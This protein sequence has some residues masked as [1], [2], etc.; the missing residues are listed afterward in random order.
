MEELKNK[1][2]NSQI[3]RSIFRHGYPDTEKNR[4]LIIITNFFL[5][6]HPAKMKKHGMKITYTWC[7]GGISFF[8]F[9]VLTVTGILLMFYYRPTVE[10]AYHDMKDLEFVVT[11]GILLRNLH[12]WA[13]HGMV[14]TVI[15]HMV[16]VFLTGSY[17]PPREF[18]WGIGVSL[19]VLTV[20]LSYTG[21]LLP[22]DQLAFWGVTVGTN[23][24]S[25][26]PFLGSEGP[27][28]IVD[29]G[30]D[31]RFLMLGGRTVGQ[32]ALLRFY[33]L[34]VIALPLI[35]VIFMAVHFWR[36]RKDGGIS[37]PL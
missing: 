34:H 26:V 18:N 35:M 6:L 33:V 9:F 17:R 28:S 14:L 16:R 8:L 1:I 37:T 15:L 13:A 31:V 22:W 29:A 24:A 32:N 30:S 19:L 4:V 5:H 11:L 3:W 7:L 23:M 36:I 2:I 10:Y 27:F 25:A 12:R 21:Y 20:L